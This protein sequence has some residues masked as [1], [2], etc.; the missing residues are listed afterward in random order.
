MAKSV[1]QAALDKATRLYVQ[2][3]MSLHQIAAAMPEISQ[4]TLKKWSSRYGWVKMRRRHRRREEELL[5]LLVRLKVGLARMAVPDEAGEFKINP[6]VV[7]ALCRVVTVLNPPASVA[8]R[9]W[10]KE[11]AEAGDE[12]VEDKMARV[13]DLLK[14]AGFIP[15]DNEES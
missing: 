1:R 10:E 11:E 13:M 3:N 5:D 15:E 2:E 6:S 7:N 14:G 12:S 4:S 8:L 9:Q